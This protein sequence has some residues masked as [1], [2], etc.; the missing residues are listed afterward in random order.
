M[1]AT[2]EEVERSEERMG[3]GWMKGDG[4]QI[5]EERMRKDEREWERTEG[6]NECISTMFEKKRHNVHSGAMT[7][8]QFST[9]AL[10]DTINH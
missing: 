8:K 6:R 10:T 1:E 9:A 4:G 3:W 2:E 5:R 7:K